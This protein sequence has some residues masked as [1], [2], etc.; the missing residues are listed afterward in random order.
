MCYSIAS[1]VSRGRP[2][3][4]TSVTTFP[5]HLL[6]KDSCFS[7]GCSEEV[8]ESVVDVDCLLWAVGRRPL[9]DG[10]ELD[11]VGVN[12]ESRGYIQVDEMQNTSAQG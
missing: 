7:T 5:T 3:G 6:I 1:A 8:V 10:L 9:V 11:S 4:T 2:G 12:L